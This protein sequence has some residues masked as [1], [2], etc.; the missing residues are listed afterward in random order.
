MET[1][2]VVIPTDFSVQAE[3]A[4]IMVKRLEEKIPLKV[5]FLHIMPV[6]DTVSMDASGTISTCGEI[7]VQYVETQRD[8]AMRKLNNL[9][10][11]YGDDVQVHLRLGKITD[12]IL[13]FAEEQKA[14]LIVMGTKGA[15]GLKEKISGSETQMIARRSRI[16][17]LSLM[18][19]RSDLK[20]ENILLVHDFAQPDKLD[21]K[22]MQK[23]MDAFACR[24]HLLKVTSGDPNAEQ[25]TFDQQTAKF[26]ALNN[27]KNYETHLIRDT[28]VENGVVHFNQMLNMDVICIGTH[29]HGGLLHSS[30]TEKLVNHLYKPIISFHLN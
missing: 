16:P 26:A 25:H 21:L 24:L 18:C 1:L 4:F 22:V 15:F 17:L 27:I 11:L 7:D 28:D 30:A 10:S 9:K 8:I 6:P 2:N 20:I 13:K 12:G 5:N 3:Y 14:D 19:D 29:G 23:L